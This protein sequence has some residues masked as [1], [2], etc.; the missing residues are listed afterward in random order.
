[1]GERYCRCALC[2]NDTWR[3]VNAYVLWLLAVVMV[4]CSACRAYPALR[5]TLRTPA[6]PVAAQVAEV[7]ILHLPSFT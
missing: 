2:C 5:A 1:M 4:C 7:C 6:F 3:R